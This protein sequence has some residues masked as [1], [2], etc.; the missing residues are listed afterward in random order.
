MYNIGAIY[1]LIITVPKS[2][3]NNSSLDILSYTEYAII[4]QFNIPVCIMYYIL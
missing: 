4:I 1:S 2:T 3:Q